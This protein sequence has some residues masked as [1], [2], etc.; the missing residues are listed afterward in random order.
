MAT[1]TLSALSDSDT[2]TVK[3]HV[4]IL[5]LLAVAGVVTG[6]M[7]TLAIVFLLRCHRSRNNVVAQN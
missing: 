3:V 7:A 6:S 2:D 4:R 1:T 5:V